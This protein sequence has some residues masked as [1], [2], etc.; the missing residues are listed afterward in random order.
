M[1]PEASNNFCQQYPATARTY[2]KVRRS[3]VPN[4]RGCHIPLDSQLNI[5]A[6]R[7]REALISNKSLVG[8][9]CYR[10]PIDFESDRILAEGKTN[11]GSVVRYKNDVVKF[12]EEETRLKALIGP[13]AS[14]PFVG[15]NR[16]N[17]LMMR[18]LSLPPGDSVNSAI[19]AG[20]LDKL[21]NPMTLA[22][23]GPGWKM[24]KV[25]LSFAGGGLGGRHADSCGYVDSAVL[26][27]LRHG[28]LD[29]LGGAGNSHLTV[30]L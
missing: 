18:P 2:D 27:G 23:S 12:L 25:D 28:G 9:L 3:G 30:R 29:C 8:M 10:F 19:R 5:K 15:T 1:W 22:Q 20:K 16:L 26:F 17:P 13:F 6:W 21:P 4:Y 7:E 24:F 14:A 11:H